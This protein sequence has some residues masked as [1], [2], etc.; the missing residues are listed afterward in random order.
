MP[1]HDPL[2][3]QVDRRTAGSPEPPLLAVTDLH[4]SFRG[5]HAVAG[6]NLA[7]TQGQTVSIIG[8]NG[9]GKTTTL[10][11]ISG[12]LKPD[13]G[14]IVMAGKQI[15][16][17]GPERAAQAGISR[18]FQNGRVFGALSVAQNVEIGMHVT[19]TATRPLQA[20]AG[21][22]VLTWLPL[23]G[24][25]WLALFP[26]RRARSENARIVTDV[27]AQLA[28]FADRLGPRRDEPA[29]SLSYANRRR[30]E[31]ARAL[32]AEPRLLVLDEPT[33]GMNQTETV[34][35]LAQLQELKSAGQ[36]ILLVEHKL[37]LV[38][39]LSDHVIVMDDGRVI[40]Q[41]PPS[42]IRSDPAV[43]QA[44]LGSRSTAGTL[45]G[46]RPQ[47]MLGDNR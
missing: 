18:T 20:L 32:A 10:N 37:D 19:R 28:R 4:R 26:G 12:V 40:A 30:T 2:S 36:T 38:M 15:G 44:Y 9:S 41:G 3:E 33:A 8:P 7:I 47:Q 23:L 35:V 5:V 39:S 46:R 11:L 14:T 22:P 16:G 13:S 1:D 42:Q 27:D 25:L 21:K 31:I 34:Q 24:E 45:P 17:H 6:V 43:I 29:F